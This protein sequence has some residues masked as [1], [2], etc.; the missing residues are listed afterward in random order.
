M[1]K[2]T[3]VTLLV[4]VV[5]GIGAFL[6]LRAPEKGERKGPHVGPP[7]VSAMKADQIDALEVVNGKDASG[8]EQKTSLAKQAG[9]WTVV[10]PV[11]YPADAEGV[12]SA[13]D[14]LAELSFSEVVSDH[15]DKQKEL[16]VDQDKGVR[17]TVK[18]GGKVLADLYFGKTVSGYTMA[19]VAGQDAI[20]QSS[21][22]QKWAFAK[23]TKGWRD[24]VVTDFK[25]DDIA[26]IT[27]D[28]GARGKI[29]VKRVAPDKDKGTP[30]KFEVVQSS[31]KIDKL[32]DS[33]P[34][35][36]ASSVYALRA[37]DFADAAAAAETGL[38]KPGYTITTEAGGKKHVVLVG[39]AKGDNFYVKTGDRTQVFLL[40]KYT[41]E[42]L[43]K[44]PIEFRDKTLCDLKA[45]AV[46]ALDITYGGAQ[47]QLEKS[48]SDWK[49]RKPAIAVDA[50]K[51]VPITQSFTNFKAWAFAE[52]TDPKT[53]GLK[54]PTARITV[55]TSD[56][57]SITFAVGALKD[58]DY[59][60]Q[61]V[62]RP[63]VYMVKKY[64]LDRML[65][66]PDDVKKADTTAKKS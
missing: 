1:N 56:K 57:K 15:K 30:E 24:K 49:A 21:G 7:G 4:F 28:A 44:A 65:K 59:F 17:V 47:L 6:A 19:R 38:D 41:I 51:V 27:V 20:W 58:Q 22:I 18:S 11:V 23:D 37:F 5:L 33:V 46:T 9:K 61:V 53:T 36:L 60:L 32:D 10:A 66:K 39:K 16:E 35:G 12:K 50:T 52:S 54:K 63:D 48:G 13:V 64:A 25:R 26:T 40:P 34:Q 3:T 29:T 42:R 14:K 43:A 62:G 55:R 8:K 2:K 31:V 45:D